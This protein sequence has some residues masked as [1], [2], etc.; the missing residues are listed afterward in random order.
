MLLKS[1]KESRIRPDSIEA[2]ERLMM[3]LSLEQR[4]F[5]TD[6]HSV[7]DINSAVTAAGVAGV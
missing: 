7:M 5:S 4:Y 1:I 6:S 3:P 2:A